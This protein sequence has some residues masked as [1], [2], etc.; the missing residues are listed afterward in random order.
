MKD[1]EVM[2]IFEEIAN[3]EGITADMVR[4]EIQKVIYEAIRNASPAVLER[5]KRIPSEGTVPTPEE[6]IRYVAAQINS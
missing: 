1:P 3:R 4:Y 5:W 6:L 2:Q